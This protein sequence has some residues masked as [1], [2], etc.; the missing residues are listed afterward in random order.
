MPEREPWEL[1]RLKFQKGRARPQW[2]AGAPL[3]LEVRESRKKKRPEC[4][5]VVGQ[6]GLLR[7]RYR[8]GGRVREKAKG[9]VS[10]VERWREGLT[11]SLSSQISLSEASPSFLLPSPRAPAVG[12]P[13]STAVLLINGC[14][15]LSS[16][17]FTSRAT[18]PHPGTL[19]PVAKAMS[20][21]L[22][23]GSASASRT[24][25]ES[26]E[27]LCCILSHPWTLPRLLQ[28]FQGHSVCQSTESTHL[29]E[30]PKAQYSP[31]PSHSFLKTF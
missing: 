9:L 23:E 5:C 7:A 6:G 26:L 29:T 14:S 27:K 25:F 10:C 16:P 12:L 15:V 19:R 20:I 8:P 22:Q 4:A 3:G 18:Q 21:W 28:A 17:P 11:A 13:H 1:R 24:A 31:V 2:E 30:A